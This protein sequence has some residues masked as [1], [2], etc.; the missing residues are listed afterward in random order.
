MGHSTPLGNTKNLMFDSK[1]WSSGKDDNIQVFYID[2]VAMPNG[3]WK[4]EYCKKFSF[5]INDNTFY[6]QI[7]ND[8]GVKDIG[9]I[10]FEDYKEQDKYKNFETVIND[11][12]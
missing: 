1:R 9:K 4:G 6:V 11:Y 3:T 10:S 12:K 5:Y 7:Y 2:N 8:E